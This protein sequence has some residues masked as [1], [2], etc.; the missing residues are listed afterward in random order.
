MG[1]DLR[2]TDPLKNWVVGHYHADGADDEQ[3]R[4][5]VRDALL[6]QELSAQKFAELSE[7]PPLR[8]DV[9]LTDALRRWVCG[10]CAL[11][12][13][14]A[15]SVVTE[16]LFKAIETNMLS[17]EKF[18]SLARS[19]ESDTFAAPSHIQKAIDDAVERNTACIL[20]GNTMPEVFHNSSE[21][22]TQMSASLSSQVMG[23][24]GVAQS[25]NGDRVRVKDAA[26][27]YSAK[28]AT[29]LHV[30]TG[31]PVTPDFMGG[32]AVENPSEWDHA[33]AGVLLK[34]SAM[35]AGLNVGWSEGDQNILST[36]V[37]EDEW[38]GLVGNEWQRG[39]RGNRVK[40]LLSE[41][42]GS[43]GLSLTPVAFDESVI[44]KPLLC[45][46][47]FPFVEVL[48]VPRGSTIEG[49]TIGTPTVVWNTAEG[50]AQDLFSTAGLVG[51]LSHTIHPVSVFLEVGRDLLAD[52][53][54]DV[55]RV[56][57]NAI[58]E[59]FQAEFDKVIAIGDGVTQPEG[60]FTASAGNVVDSANGTAG[61]LAM[62]DF[63]ALAFGIA[64]QYRTPAWGPAF[65]LNDATY[66]RGRTIPTAVNWNTRAMGFKESDYT[67][68]EWPARIQND[69]GPEK[70]AFMPLRKYRMY[71]RAGL[72]IR[73]TDQGMTLARQNAI[74]LVCRARYSGFITD[75]NALATM[76]DAPVLG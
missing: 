6:R 16:H 54:I 3:V 47:L 22:K 43:G 40:A 67:L 31:Q 37:N 28:R 74:L 62:E 26:E 50:T 66:R 36:I 15:D 18:L 12:E 4:E 68:I 69:I 2:L 34:W 24:A 52:A 11:P 71:R 64:K 13:T 1:S 21:R 30:K 23:S 61:P 17:E 9:P 63:E 48:D 58:G 41:S 32:K 76:V 45:G 14:A 29:G 8:R 25:G 44:S 35:R 27:S 46:E 10:H 53:P 39:L 20:S 5:L 42:G 7:R 70:I 59:R 60:I 65:V 49:A 19:G 57:V 55:G 56:L 51:P 38:C 33:R 75:P 73:F 72:E